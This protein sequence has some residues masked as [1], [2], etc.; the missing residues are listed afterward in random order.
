MYN[1]ESLREY[2]TYEI[3]RD[4]KMQTFHLIQTLEIINKINR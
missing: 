3:L 2:E 1:P 4:F